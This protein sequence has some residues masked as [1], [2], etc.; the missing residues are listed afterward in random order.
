M[1]RFIFPSIL[2]ALAV[3]LF[4]V[5][6]NKTYQMT[7]GLRV[8]KAAY[9]EALLNSRKLLEVRDELTS[10]FNAITVEDRDRLQKLMPDNVDNIRLI[11]DIQKIAGKYGMLPRDIHFDP[12]AKG[13]QADAGQVP[14]A[15]PSELRDANREYGSFSLDFSVG[16]SYANFLKFLHDLENSLRI[17]DIE[18]ITFSSNDGAGSS[19]KY[20]FKIRTYWLKN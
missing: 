10:R 5:Y 12:I 8:T 18:S 7:T 13:N 14:N 19:Y 1:I 16:G 15:T 3:G 17:M 4:L 20:N 2:I 9:D 6:T 11:I